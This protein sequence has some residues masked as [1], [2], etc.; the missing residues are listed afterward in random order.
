MLKRLKQ[1]KALE[2]GARRL[3]LRASALLPF[4]S[5]SLRLRGFRATQSGLQKLI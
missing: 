3:F 2:P 1:F 4:I 5:L